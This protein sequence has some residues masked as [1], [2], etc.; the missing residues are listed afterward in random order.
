M[1][2]FPKPAFSYEYRLSSQI[3]ALRRYRDT[4]PGRAIP[5]KA[6]DRLL[7][8]TWNVANLGVQERREKDYL[9]IAEI[10][11]W[12]DLVAMQEVNNDLSGLRA[13]HR[14]LPRSFRLLFS[15]TAG[16]EERMAFIYD[17]DKVT[18]LEE[19]GEVAIPPSDINDIRLPGITQ[20]F[21]G[22]DRNPYLAGFSSDSFV[23]V[24]VNVHLYFGS[25]S[26]I[27][28][29]RR[30][31]ETYA[32]ARWADL[33][34]QSPYA[35]SRD[36][37]ALGD[38]NLPKAEP[39]D[40]IFEALTRRGLH[41]PEHST[42]IGS[43]IETDS[44]YDQVAFFPGETQQEFTGNLGVFDFDGA[45]FRTLWEA[46]TPREFFAYVRYYVSD[47]RPLWAEFRL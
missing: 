18:L 13:I 1:P 8:A 16:N 44:H 26:A 10:V 35:Y 24:L 20:A 31:L 32:V 36:I 41:L 12:F 34:R 22:F 2:P 28:M 46:R 23:Y 21:E 39:G 17:S 9:L 37:I 38:F 15:D 40:P 33:R 14:H 43:T 6:A 19:V 45:L 42:Q 11:S 25:E 47:H 5:A 27:S 7:V 30:R 4:K 29:N 3:D